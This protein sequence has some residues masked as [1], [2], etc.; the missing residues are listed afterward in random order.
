M[1]IF[2][3]VKRCEPRDLKIQNRVFW[4]KWFG[5]CTC[6]NLN[7]PINKTAADAYIVNIKIQEGASSVTKDK[8]GSHVKKLQ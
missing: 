2:T 1:W 8:A 3:D 6:S 5:L 4:S 7:I